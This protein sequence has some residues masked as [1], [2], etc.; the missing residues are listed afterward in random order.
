MKHILFLMISTLSL[1]C[2]SQVYKWVDENGKT[3]YSSESP[4]E[5][6]TIALPEINKPRGTQIS[7]VET[8]IPTVMGAGLSQPAIIIDNI[9]MNIKGINPYV[10]NI[11]QNI[12][13]KN[14]PI[15][16]DN[17]RL[18]GSKQSLFSKAIELVFNNNN[19]NVKRRFHSFVDQKLRLKI[20]VQDLSL[21]YCNKKKLSSSYSNV[22]LSQATSK[23]KILW[24]LYDDKENKIIEEIITEGYFDGLNEPAAPNGMEFSISESFKSATLNLL[25]NDEFTS[26]IFKL[27]PK[28]TNTE[29]KPNIKSINHGHEEVLLKLAPVKKY[30]SVFSYTSELSK[31]TVEINQ[32]ELTF[33][34]VLLN[35]D[36]YVLTPNIFSS[37]DGPVHVKTAGISIEA[38]LIRVNKDLNV[39]LLKMREAKYAATNIN[40]KALPD[41]HE[42]LLFM[43]IAVLDEAPYLNELYAEPAKQKGEI[44]RSS[45]LSFNPN[46]IGY[47]LF[48]LQGEF[49]AILGPEDGDNPG[50][51]SVM[52]VA[53]LFN[54]VNVTPSMTSFSIDID[55]NE[56]SLLQKTIVVIDRIKE[57]LNRPI[58]TLD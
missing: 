57:W 23:I 51:H 9:I 6:N 30:D 39:S 36:G 48:N 46:Y 20:Q 47:P 7:K 42:A 43:V 13:N 24:T 58:M 40:L 53:S 17:G 21:N 37:V 25:S 5:S 55:S 11:G 44:S 8:H 22:R 3:H 28:Q 33:R 16:W 31:Y 54:V 32:S 15:T 4:G 19:Y 34:G 50:K 18:S 45:S 56:M 27:I 2:Y 10:V 14:K 49:L 12:C 38:E 26:A 35:E 52:S 29:A 41:N 1:S